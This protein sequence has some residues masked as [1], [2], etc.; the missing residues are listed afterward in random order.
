MKNIHIHKGE[1]SIIFL[2]QE[3]FSKKEILGLRLAQKVLS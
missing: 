1:F 3:A 2:Q